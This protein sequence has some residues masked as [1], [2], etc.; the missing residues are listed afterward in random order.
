M[1]RSI[2]KRRRLRR[3]GFGETLVKETSNV[4]IVSTIVGAVLFG[5]VFLWVASKAPK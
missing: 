4:L 5:A 3:N 2:Q 1:S